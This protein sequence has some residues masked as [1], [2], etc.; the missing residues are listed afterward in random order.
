[1][2]QIQTNFSDYKAILEAERVSIHHMVQ[3]FKKK[4]IDFDEYGNIFIG[5]N[6]KTAGLPILVAHTDNVLRGKREP[7]F[8]LNKRQ[9]FGKSA[10]IGF[11]DK[12]G[13]IAIIQLWKAFE[14][15]QR[16]RIIFTADEEVGGVGA[17]EIDPDIYADAAWILELDRKGDKDLI[18]TSGTVKLCSDEF[19]SKF[20]ELGFKKAQ[21][22]FTDVNIFKQNFYDVNMANLSIG[23]YNPHSDQ[24]YLDTKAFDEIV[25][26]VAQFIDAQY[27]F[28]PDVYVEPSWK[29]TTGSM[30]PR[31]DWNDGKDD[32][33]YCW[34]CGEMTKNKEDENGRTFCGSKCKQNYEDV[35]KENNNG[36]L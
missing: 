16:F 17:Q 25:N 8:D 28:E 31:W 36:K 2:K 21:G 3:H 1:M 34:Y 7:I 22:T 14:K 27:V 12:A 10:G 30:S 9:L 15:E 32:W 13:I 24:E 35:M 26:K 4:D 29:H 18:Q 33:N 5:F 11:D 23:Y 19:A 6:K 20:E